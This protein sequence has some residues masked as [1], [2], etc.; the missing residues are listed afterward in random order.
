MPARRKKRTANKK[1]Y[2]PQTVLHTEEARLILQENGFDVAGPEWVAGR[3]VF[4]AKHGYAPREQVFSEL[5]VF[6]VEGQVCITQL[7]LDDF[8]QREQRRHGV[9]H[10]G[11]GITAIEVDAAL[12]QA[13]SLGADGA[14]TVDPQFG[15]E[16]L[17]LSVQTAGP[18]GQPTTQTLGDLAVQRLPDGRVVVDVRELAVVLAKVPASGSDSL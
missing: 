9:W 6:E 14:M 11:T 5:P 8:I 13:R 4:E 18:D 2:E 17:R 15:R 16:T 12:G 1:R 3:W 7:V 10:G